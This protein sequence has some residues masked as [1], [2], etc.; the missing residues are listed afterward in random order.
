MSYK[1]KSEKILLD[2]FRRFMKS[3]A[4]SSITIRKVLDVAGVYYVVGAYDHLRDV[5]VSL[6]LTREEVKQILHVNQV[7]WIK[8]IWEPADDLE[9]DEE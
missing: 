9:D 7:F 8:L 5:F 6:A 2:D 1:D 3:Q 4:L